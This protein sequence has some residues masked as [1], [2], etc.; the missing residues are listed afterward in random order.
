MPYI[1]QLPLDIAKMNIWLGL[2]LFVVC[3]S[4]KM[5]KQL[6]IIL[7]RLFIMQKILLDKTF[8][9]DGSIHI[10]GKAL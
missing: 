3:I 9:I 2:F 4:S 10:F 5:K 1:I 7:S 8:L 6:Q